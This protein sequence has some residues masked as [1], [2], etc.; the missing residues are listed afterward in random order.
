[1]IKINTKSDPRISE[2]FPNDPYYNL[3]IITSTQRLYL[4]QAFLSMDS[5]YFAQINSDTREV[6][7]RELK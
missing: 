1:M 2:A 4:Q 3:C 6:D 5:D 7:L